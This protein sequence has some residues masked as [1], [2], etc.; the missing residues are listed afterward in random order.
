MGVHPQGH[1]NVSGGTV[2]S[3]GTSHVG[4]R[5][6]PTNAEATA[7]GCLCEGWGAADATT[8]VTGYANVSTDGVVNLSNRSFAASGNSAR[9]VVDVGTSLQVTHDYRPSDDD[10]LYAVTV[11]IKNISSGVVDAR[12][13]RVMDWDVEPT[14]FNEFVTSRNGGS[15]LLRYNNND[16]FATANPL[17]STTS[18]SVSPLVSGNF[19]DVGPTDHGAL[20]DFGFGALDPG[21]TKSFRTFYGAAGTEAEALAALTAVAADVYSLGQPNTP[22][23]PTVGSPNT[24]IFGFGNLGLVGGPLEPAETLGGGS[25]GGSSGAG[26]GRFVGGNPSYRHSAQCQEGWPVNCVT[27]NFWH[28]FGDVTVAGRGP[29]LH[30]ARTFNSL[31]ADADGPFGFGWSSNVT[32]RLDVDAAGAASVRQET[33]AVAEFTLDGTGSYTA[34][35]RVLATLAKAAT[36][37]TFTRQKRERFRFDLD[38]RLLELRD[39]DGYALTYTRDAAGRAVSMSDSAGRVLSLAYDAAGR[40]VGLTD[41]AGRTVGYGYD[42]VGNLTS[43]TDVAGGVESF[44]YD[45]QHR[46]VSMIDPRGGVVR[47]VYDAQSRVV[48]QTDPSL[49]RTTFGYADN[50]TTVTHPSGRVDTH[51]HLD[52]LVTELTRGAGTPSAATAKFSYD[53]YTMGVVAAT[54]PNGQMT[55]REFDRSGNLLS[56]TDSL[57]RRTVFTYGPLDEITSVSDPAGVSSTTTYD[58]R[59]N[60]LVVSRPLTGTALTQRTELFYGDPSRPG[61]VTAITD[62]SGR[63]SRFSYDDAGNL[64]GTTDA[65]GAASSYSYDVLGWL[66]S[67]VSPR[68]TVAGANPVDHRT[69]LTYNAFGDLTTMVDPIGSR[70]E[71]GYDP[72]RNLITTRDADGKTTAYTYDADDRVT[73]VRR[74]DGTTLGYGYDAIGNLTSQSDGAGQMTR[75][76]YDVLD[77]LEAVTDPLA[78][79][80]RMSYDLAG[81]RTG[82]TDAAGRTTAASYDAAGQLMAVDF[83]DAATPDVSFGYDQLGRRSTMTDGTG[84]TSYAWDSLGRLTATTN[85]AGSFVGYGYDLA[86]RLTAITYPNGRTV[87]RGHDA[88]GRFDSV[89]DWLGNTTRFGYDANSN[90]VSEAFGNGTTATSTYDNSDRLT[91]IAHAGPPGALAGF[92]YTRTASGLLASTDSSGVAQPDESYAYTQL[93]E[94]AAVSTSAGTKTLSYDPAGNITRLLSG[95]SQTYDAG[96]QALTHTDSSGRVTPLSY[97]ALGNRL[98]GLGPDGGA[99]GYG[100]DQANRL[101]TATGGGTGSASGLLSAGQYHSL[102][103]RQDGT[104]W[105]WG[106]NSSGQLGHGNTANSSTPRQVSGVSGAQQVAGGAVH[107]A[108]LAGGSVWTWGANGF[109]QLGDGTT[110]TR[111]RP[112]QVSGLAGITQVAAGNYHT[113]AVDERAGTV[114]A[115]GL[116]NAYQLGDGTVTNRRTPV[117]VTGLSGVVSVAAGGLPGYAGHSVALKGDGTVWTWGYGKSGQLGL[118]SATSTPTPTKVDGL[119]GIVAVAAGGDNTYALGG[120]GAVY[121]WGDNSYGQI[122]NPSARRAQSTPLAVALSGAATSIA[123]A[124]THALAVKVDGTAWAWGNNNTGQ[125]GDGGACGKTCGAPVR[126]NGLTDVS[127]LA[128]G[129]VHSLAAAGDG[130]V[131]GWGR[132]AEGQLGDGTTTARFTPAATTGLA[133]VKAGPPIDAAYGYDG[134]GLR[135]SKSSAGGAQSFTWD[136]AASVPLLLSDGTTSYIYGPGGRPV[137][138]IDAGGKA[139]FYHRDQIGS[140]RLLTDATGAIVATANYDAYGQRSATT[141]EQITLGYAGE[142]HDS[143]TGLTYLRARYY[144][145]VTA[146][147]L[148]RDPLAAQS[149]APYAYAGNTPLNATDP[150][151]QIA[152]FAVAAVVWAVVEIGAAVSDA[153]STANTFTDPCASFWE[154]AGSGALLGASIGLPG[155]GYS[156]G[157]RAVPNNGGLYGRLK[158]AG[159]GNQI[160]HTPANKVSPRT[161]YSGPAIRMSAD[162]HK[163]TASYG[164]SPAAAAYRARQKAL[165][166]QGRFDDA[167]QMDIDDIRTKFGSKYDEAI[168]E[169]IDSL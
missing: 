35:P 157:A 132:N 69:R 70:V 90:L 102:A 139:R 144:D 33:G 18:G 134:D 8:G 91:G 153:Y 54:D 156:T 50:L 165:I 123:A 107:T 143:D 130:T 65:G 124:G 117:A 34:A 86:S 148:T 68:G 81:R 61:D 151:G 23:G 48:E 28:T 4:L 154:K 116:N 108:A 111:T 104:V 126:V 15:P 120:D 163:L 71:R 73:G 112:V 30:V 37:Y 83:S 63:T 66:T 55:A 125:L 155:G 38:G 75:Y 97:D 147:F 96:S 60:P 1:L 44:G 128:G 26:T 166:D 29:D 118:G 45:A 131:R 14:A 74:P 84:T 12:Y 10:N 169:M 25:G 59:A 100:Y 168:L 39:L 13:R 89:T 19:T 145:P 76:G 149:G 94:L 161:M 92:G 43:V 82:T 106:G 119:A 101:V 42:A 46:V 138:H 135:T 40:V 6:L 146:Q 32:M 150:T 80:T 114:S 17:G 121:A 47:N 129:Y 49:A 160:H 16:G 162:D 5:Y 56:Q 88:T 110:S 105:S 51:Q 7:P 62:P 137:E 20:F 93:D 64:I 159:P 36:G 167:V 87:N 122:G 77:R 164:S 103:V 11:S 2:S 136:V 22:D 95:A 152:W 98:N 109:G 141:G 27:G 127:A 72:N 58:A 21:E 9:S 67:A 142:Y 3:G 24:F 79:T 133:D 99:V 115:W 85:G 53:P 140:T 31:A 158:P 41:P 52:G 57:A 78:R 113:L